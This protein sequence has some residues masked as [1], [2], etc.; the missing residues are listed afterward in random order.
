V[1][2]FR[3]PPALQY[4]LTRKT[5][6]KI[7]DVI[8]KETDG[9]VAISMGYVGLAATNTS[10]NNMLLFMRGPDDGE[11]RVRLDEASKVRLGDLR[12][13]LRKAVPEAV[14]PWLTETFEKHEQK[15]ESAARRAK[16][17]ALGFEPGE[18]VN[19]VMSLGSPMPV[20]VAVAGPNCEDVRPH[21][22]KILGELKKI[23]TLRDVQLYQQLDYPAVR[24]DIDRQRAGLSGVT[25]KD[26]ADTLLVGTPPA[27]TWTRIIGA[28][29][30]AAST[31]RCK[32]RFPLRGWTARSRSRRCRCKKSSST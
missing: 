5:A 10:T 2:R 13:R 32:S 29:R 31:I 25:I 1:L 26:V 18:I 22:L 23:G 4:E 9:Q 28:T 21:V 8:D 30:R 15:P 19:E 24:V 17:F 14:V 3:A 11:L 20:E 12:E 27:A 6:I 7:L 16:L